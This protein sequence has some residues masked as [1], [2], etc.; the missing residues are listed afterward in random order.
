MDA[1]YWADTLHQRL[2]RR[3]ALAATA[4][5]SFGAAIAAACGG[6]KEPS[7]NSDKS[8]LLAPAVDE[9]Q[10]AV[11]GGTFVTAGASTVGTLDAH[12]NN[13]TAVFRE[14]FNIYSTPLKAGKAIGKMPS[15]SAITGDA[16]ESWEVFPDGLQISLKLRQNHKYN[17]RPPTN[18]RAMTIEDVIVRAGTAPLRPRP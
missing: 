2:T 3:R 11:R 1:H 4:G 6:S 5:V 16:F 18:G 17:P 9:S 15:P 13:S 14:M 7:G 10:K 12:L 8:G